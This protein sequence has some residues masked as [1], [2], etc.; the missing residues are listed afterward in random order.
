[1]KKNDLDLAE[2]AGPVDGFKP[3]DNVVVSYDTDLEIAVRIRKADTQPGQPPTAPQTAPSPQPAVAANAG[4]PFSM[5]FVKIPAGR[6]KMGSPKNEPG[7]SPWEQQVDVRITEDFEIGKCEVTQRQWGLVMKTE[8]WKGYGQSTE[9]PDHPATCVGWDGAMQFCQKLTEAEHS[10]GTLPREKV[11]RLPTEA[12]WEYAC[13]AGSTTAFSFGDD[14]SLLDRYGWAD[15]QPPRAVGLK[16]PNAWGVLDMHGNVSEWCLDWNDM[17][18]LAGGDDPLGPEP[19]WQ[20]MQR[21]GHS[22]YQAGWMHRS[23][24]RK[25]HGTSGSHTEGF[26]VVKGGPRPITPPAPAIKE[27]VRLPPPKPLE[28]GETF[29]LSDEALLTLDFQPRAGQTARITKRL[30]VPGPGVDFDIEYQGNVDKDCSGEWVYR[31]MGATPA[32][33]AVSTDLT[34]YR[35]FG[36]Q[37]EVL[38][39]DGKRP[40]SFKAPLLVGSLIAGYRPESIDTADGSRAVSVTSFHQSFNPLKQLGFVVNIPG[41]W[42]EKDPSKNPWPTRGCVIHLRVS[43]APGAVALPLVGGADK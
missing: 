36:L 13:R 32:T 37:F 10:R 5:D 31:V 18:P 30:D 6:F 12:E 24:Y 15:G 23:A 28:A 19:G 39:V 14:A 4:G 25:D 33:A 8:P 26:R 27:A 17:K 20:R 29:T 9:G 11:Y 2:S 22:R 43:P 40:A 38:G 16:Q 3:G 42:Y 34:P 35:A 7:N 1:M 41:W 21:G